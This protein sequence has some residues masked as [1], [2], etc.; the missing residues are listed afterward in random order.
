MPIQ[1][2]FLLKC[3][4]YSTGGLQQLTWHLYRCTQ[5]FCWRLHR[6][7]TDQ[8][9]RLEMKQSC[10]CWRGYEELSLRKPVGKLKSHNNDKVF[11][12]SFFPLYQSYYSLTELYLGTSFLFAHSNTF[13][14]FWVFEYL[15]S[16]ILTHIYFTFSG[17]WCWIVCQDIYTLL[18]KI[19][20]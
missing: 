9:F 4:G 5:G 6:Q 13:V 17:K 16:Q 15:F 1:T 8:V 19:S 11:I 7:I 18:S 12:Y 20:S 14:L 3:T 10:Y 2:G